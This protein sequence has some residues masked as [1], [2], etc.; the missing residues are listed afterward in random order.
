MNTKAFGTL[1]KRELWENKGSLVW[2][3]IIVAAVLALLSCWAVVR[4]AYEIG[5]SP[6]I[7]LE[8][9]VFKLDLLAEKLNS[10]TDT[11]RV[12]AVQAGL[13]GLRVPFDLLLLIILPFYCVAALYDDR[14]DRSIYFWRSLPVSDLH[15]VLA[16]LATAVVVY[17]A[18]VLAAAAAF[19]LIWMLIATGLSWYVGVSA[20]STVWAPSHLPLFWLS[21]YF[22]YLLMM[23]WVLPFFALNLLLSATTKRPLMLAIVL[24][25]VL[26]LVEKLLTGTEY[27]ADWIGERLVGMA[28]LLW[29]DMRDMDKMG[30]H[31]PF[32]S[33]SHGLEVFGN[34]QFWFG[35]LLSIALLAGAV[36]A[37]RRLQDV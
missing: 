19:Q 35:L 4:G 20:W 13:M 17:P 22:H 9:E 23:L 6:E 5:H 8:G 34:G 7:H 26:M 18:V 29:G 24:P 1:I 27:I 28:T 30:E 11:E 37:R 12:Q 33:Y 14:K 21:S 2:T 10:F 15:T 31:Y 25:L 32:A 16:K 3:P 36:Y